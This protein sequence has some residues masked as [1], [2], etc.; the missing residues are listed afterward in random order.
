VQDYERTGDV[1]RVLGISGAALVVL[2][3]AAEVVA[4]AYDGSPQVRVD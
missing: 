1:A 4:L 2:G 3:L